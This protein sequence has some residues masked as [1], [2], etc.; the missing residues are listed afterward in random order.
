MAREVMSV[1]KLTAVPVI[2]LCILSNFAQASSHKYQ[3]GTIVAV[4]GHVN[5]EREVEDDVVRYDVS[6]KIG[7]VLYVVLYTP[8]NGA[9]LVEYLPGK[10]MLFLV[11]QGTLTFNSKISGAEEM[12]ILRQELLSSQQGLD[13][14]RAPGQYFSMKQQ[15]ISE[16][17]NLTTEQQDQIKP[18]LEQETGEVGQIFRNPVLSRKQKLQKYEKIVETSDAKIKPHLSPSQ[19]K[20]LSDLRKQQK[21]D[22]RTLVAKENTD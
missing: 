19:L 10:Q 12:P 14:S 22:L 9:R 17:L 6:V 16:V 2:C 13:W 4:A 15:H 18:I 1:S 21:K 7:N 8:R 5:A 20:R 3:P 11:G